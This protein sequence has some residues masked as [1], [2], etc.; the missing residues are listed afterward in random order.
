MKQLLV[1]T[2]VLGVLAVSCTKD[3]E[4]VT[5]E[6]LGVYENGILVSN[7][8]PF[9]NGTGTVSF[10]SEDYTLVEDAIY[11]QEN[12]EDLGNIV[13][14]IG[15]NDD[16]AYIVVNNSNT[17]KVVNRYTFTA[18]A[19]ISEDLNNPRFFAVSNGKGYVTNWG[20]T[21]DDADDYVAVIDLT[22]HTVIKKI[23]V[24][25]GPEAILANE[26]FVYVAHKGA[27][28]QNNKVTVINTATDEVL[29][30]LT[31]GDFPN[32][33]QWDADGSLWV[34]SGGAPSYTGTETMGTL[35][36]IDVA[37]NTIVKTFDFTDTQHPDALSV[38]GNVLYYAMDNGVYAVQNNADTLP[39]DTYIG[40]VSFYAMTIAEGKLYGTD[41]KD[42]ASKGDLLIYDLASK[43]KINT[44]AVGIIPG[45]I[46]FNRRAIA[47]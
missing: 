19:T 39:L 18:K 43:E 30:T 34:L 23:A 3:D 21:A 12:N 4:V 29:K 47:Q 44:I 40:E 10:I 35:S 32:S 46:Y 37:T 17:I 8:G 15:F 31:V 14:S 42:Y 2:L 25:L 45:G 27:W 36:K 22:T 9:N 7:E 1:F 33:M 28:G 11:K 38:E 20:D 13:Q 6:P 41:A 26:N 5:K 16:T 24:V